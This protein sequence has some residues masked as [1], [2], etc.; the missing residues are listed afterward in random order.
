MA[1]LSVK[2]GRVLSSII[3]VA[4]LIGGYHLGG[5]E[6]A[7]RLG[8]FLIMPL[9]CISFSEAMGDYAGIL[10]RYSPMEQP[11]AGAV[12]FIGWVLLLL[13]AIQFAINRG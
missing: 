12:C 9:A 2:W 8:I 5:G 1:L 4:Y 13:P 6:V 11:P 3:A 10:A 7:G